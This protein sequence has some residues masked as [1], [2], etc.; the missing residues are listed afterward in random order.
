MLIE[1]FYY[2]PF[3]WILASSIIPLQLKICRSAIKSGH[4]VQI[5]TL[6]MP[7]SLPLNLRICICGESYSINSSSKIVLNMPYYRLL[8]VHIK[9][10]RYLS[11]FNCY[12][13]QRGVIF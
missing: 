12:A 6:A 8:I 1:Y 3:F 10:M 9:L 2:N 5:A 11:T 7:L 4:F 13:I